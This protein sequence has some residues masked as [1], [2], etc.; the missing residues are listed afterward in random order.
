MFVNRSNILLYETTCK[1]FTFDAFFEFRKKKVEMFHCF[2]G[3]YIIY[4]NMSM[5]IK[6]NQLLINYRKKCSSFFL[7]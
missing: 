4:Y 5:K 2:C 6:I 3:R 7:Q 1:K